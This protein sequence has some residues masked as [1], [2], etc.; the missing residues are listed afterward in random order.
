MHG[1]KFIIL[2]ISLHT[3]FDTIYSFLSSLISF[4][5]DNNAE[6]TMLSLFFTFNAYCIPGYAVLL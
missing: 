3:S 2:T 5:A 6:Y 1:F 4:R